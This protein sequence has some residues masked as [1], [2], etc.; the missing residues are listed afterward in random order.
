MGG[1]NV[2]VQFGD[3]HE[4]L[5]PVQ[6]AREDPVASGGCGNRGLELSGA[7]VVTRDRGCGGGLRRSSSGSPFSGAGLFRLLVI[8][9]PGLEPGWR[10][11]TAAGGGSNSEDLQNLIGPRG[12]DRAP[13]AL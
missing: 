1:A 11:G 12:G 2:V 4:E 6:G 13:G 5:D 9:A 3:G 10:P 7:G 8:P